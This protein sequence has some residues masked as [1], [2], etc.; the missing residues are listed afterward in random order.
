MSKKSMSKGIIILDCD[1]VRT[2]TQNRF[3]FPFLQRSA[4]KTL[5]GL[6][7]RLSIQEIYQG[8]EGGKTHKIKLW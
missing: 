7:N 4:V 5:I 8:N 3:L 1:T 2:F 6:R